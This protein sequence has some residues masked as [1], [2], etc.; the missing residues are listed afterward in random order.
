MGVLSDLVDHEY[1]MY[2]FLPLF[3]SRSPT[4][5]WSGLITPVLAVIPFCTCN[6]TATSIPERSGGSLSF[7]FV[8]LLL[9]PLTEVSLFQDP[10]LW[11][12]NSQSFGDGKHKYPRQVTGNDVQLGSP[13]LPYLDS[14]TY[15][16]FLLGTQHH[17]MV[18]GLRYI[19]FSRMGLHHC[20]VISKPKS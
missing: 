16:F 10:G 4:S 11:E 8:E 14:Q 20:R 13:L 3:G 9:Y 2:F 1:S 6:S 7:R 18:I 5:S 12:P 17:I 19:P 15:V